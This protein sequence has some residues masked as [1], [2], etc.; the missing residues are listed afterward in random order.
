MEYTSSMN[1]EMEE[2]LFDLIEEQYS[3]LTKKG[4]S[5]TPEDAKKL[6]PRLL[7]AVEFEKAKVANAL[8]SMRAD[9]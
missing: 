9:K 7:K 4:G 1:P 8:A 2:L 6:L 3:K 5:V